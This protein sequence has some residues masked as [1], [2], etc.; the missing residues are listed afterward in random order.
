M[1]LIFLLIAISFSI[2]VK[3]DSYSKY[4]DNST[5]NTY[6][7]TSKGNLLQ[8]QGKLDEAILYYDKALK[9][10]PRL[11]ITLTGK[12]IALGKQFKLDDAIVCFNKALEIN[13]RLATTLIGKGITLAKQGNLN[14]AILYYDKALEI[15]PNDNIALKN[16]GSALNNRG[17]ALAKQG[18][19]DDAIVCFTK[20]L[21][22]NPNDNGALKSLALIYNKNLE[23]CLM[24]TYPNLC[25]RDI[26]T[27]EDA[28]LVKYAEYKNASA[29]TNYRQVKNLNKSLD[30]DSSYGD[31][32]TITGRPKTIY[33]RGYH[34]K[35]GTYVR[36]HY[37]SSRR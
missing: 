7:L 29:N 37:R 4:T 18:K 10:N 14:E 33:V 1:R 28:K 36:G 5:N 22:I 9:I 6:A 11:A 26:L 20:A 12:G 3:A 30:N 2:F 17:V 23:T 25:K 13:P 34:R 27:L 35:D 19:L 15:N 31:I 16:K 21:A 24:G 8:S 32:S